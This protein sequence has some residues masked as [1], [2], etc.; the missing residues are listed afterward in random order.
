MATARKTPATPVKPNPRA[1]GLG[2]AEVVEDV[3]DE[4]AK[5]DPLDELNSLMAELAGSVSSNVTVYRTGRGVQRAYVFKCDA[6]SFSLDVLRDKYNGGE[7]Q[8]FITRDGVLWKN[9]TVTIEPPQAV[10]DPVPPQAQPVDAL[11]LLREDLR[12]QN[13]AVTAVLRTLAA[14]PPPPRPFLEGVNIMELVQGAGVLLNL[15]RPPAPAAPSTD[16]YV[17]ALMK[18]I[19]LAREVKAEGGD[20]DTSLMGVVKEM[21]R[22]PLLATAI[23]ATAAQAQAQAAPAPRAA[24]QLPQ[25][26][27]PPAATPPKPAAAVA[28]SPTES[29]AGE[30]VDPLLKMY[31]GVLVNKAAAQADTG[32]YAD[33]ILDNLN[34]DQLNQ[35]LDAQPSPVDWIATINS[36]VLNYRPWFETLIAEVASAMIDADDV[37][38]DPPAVASSGLPSDPTGDP[39]ASGSTTPA[40]PGESAPG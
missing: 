13:E 23:Q 28:P 40:S 15:L 25:R 17:N 21:L 11:A 37:D 1:P 12:K 19:E 26:P 22:S 10:R 2:A 6:A 34:E 33:L 7:F 20:G 32:M 8:L 39:H 36:D 16:T 31:V 18:G 14:P 35:L 24:P 38:G 9:R 29:F 30:T 3:G 27:K 4:T 5:A